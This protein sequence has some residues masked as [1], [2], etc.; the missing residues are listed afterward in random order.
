MTWY[1]PPERTGRNEDL[2]GG[3]RC[4]REGRRLARA[5]KRCRNPAERPVGSWPSKTASVAAP[6]LQMLPTLLSTF[7]ALARFVEIARKHARAAREG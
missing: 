5:Q 3:V 1:S 7:P 4:R 6:K 2:L